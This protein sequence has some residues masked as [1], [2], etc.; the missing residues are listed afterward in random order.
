MKNRLS[1]TYK[2]VDWAAQPIPYLVRLLSNHNFSDSNPSNPSDK[3]N[4]YLCSF[5]Q[6]THPL[7][8]ASNLNPQRKLHA[9]KLVCGVSRAAILYN[10]LTRANCQYVCG[11]IGVWNR[12]YLPPSNLGGFGFLLLYQRGY[13][14][15]YGGSVQ[16]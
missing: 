10:A 4:P 5:P 12:G 15:L 11:R 1:R 7:S 13:S 6:S 3:E 14:Y 2:R 8:Q 9:L 16:N